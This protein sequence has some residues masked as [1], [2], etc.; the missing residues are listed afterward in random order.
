MKNIQ[1]TRSIYIIIILILIISFL[2]YL[3]HIKNEAKTNT[4]AE[5]DKIENQVLGMDQSSNIENM[6]YEEAIDL[7][8]FM[9]L[10]SADK[11]DIA[12]EAASSMSEDNT[13][14]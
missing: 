3:G 1:K 7:L 12:K 4:R 8:I 14:E 6:S 2:V 13:I 10:I 11:V 9:D 5:N